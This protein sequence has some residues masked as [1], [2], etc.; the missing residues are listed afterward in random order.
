MNSWDYAIVGC[1][2]AGSVLANRLSADPRKRVIVIEAGPDVPPSNVPADIGSVFPL[3]AFNPEY[4]WKEAHVYSRR[5]HN[6]PRVRYPQG[7]LVG[8]T[9]AIMGMWA[10][11]G[12]PDDYDAWQAAGAAG[13]S[14]KDVLPVFRRIENDIDCGGASGH[15]S[16]GPIPIRREPFT[17][18]SPL[19]KRI[20]DQ[21]M[22]R[23]LAEIQDANSDFRDGHCVVPISRFEA[24]RASAGIC[25]LTDEVRKR[26]NLQI[27]TTTTAKDL[28]YDDGRISGVRIVDDRGATADIF[29]SETIVAAGALLSPA[30]LMRSGIGPA[31]HLR[32]L[33]M[34]VVRNI[35]GVGANLQNHPIVYCFAWLTPAGREPP[36]PRPAGSTFLRWSGRPEDD[37][38]ADMTLYIRSYL[39]WHALGRRMA[40]LAPV[41]M[42]PRSRGRVRLTSASPADYPLVEF[43]F[44]DDERDLQRMT[45]GLKRAV[46]IFSGPEMRDICH[47]PFAL[48]S[49]FAGKLNETS[50]L[51]AIKSRLAAMLLDLP[52]GAGR[53]LLERLADARAFASLAEDEAALADYV[54]RTVSGTG[55]VCGTCRMGSPDDPLAVVGS[56]GRVIGIDGLRVADASVMPL[57]P[58]AN[59]HLPTVMVAEK[60]SDAILAGQRAA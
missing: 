7:R 24:S 38:A 35:E 39:A 19:A 10:L 37:S 26:P 40:C 13:W 31:E 34:P 60:I 29:A 50:R 56:D 15:G 30:L 16:S 18:W 25:Y 53:T 8:G 2:A 27:R 45:D 44:L 5:Q 32:S 49:P 9:S 12:L 54:S 48:F 20:Y 52:S 17:E 46:E 3:S 41:L 51:N 6:S 11:R 59:T 21:S 57:L 22:A 4:Q 36:V 28:I 23:G 43:N 33:N 58:R 47:Q 55:H 42:K 1:G 14:W